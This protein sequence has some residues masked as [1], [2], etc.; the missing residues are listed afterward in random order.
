MNDL[1]IIKNYILYLKRK[2]NLQ[3][4]IHSHSS[5][6]LLK[7][8]FLTFNVHENPYCVYVKT[9]ENAQLHCIKK[10][11]QIIKK[12]KNGSFC[13]VCWAGVKE[14]IYPITHDD[15]V[16]GFISVSGFSNSNGNEY[17]SA[18]AQKY[19]LNY[20]Q[21]KSTYKT[22]KKDLPDKDYVDTLVYPLC[23][24]LELAH[25]KAAQETQTGD[26]LIG[27]IIQYLKKHYMQN[28]TSELL[29]KEFHCSRSTLSKIFNKE[30]K[31]PLREYINEI[32]IEAAKGLLMYT[33]L[34]ITEIAFS[35]GFNESY[36]FT[37]IFKKRVNMTPTQYRRKNMQ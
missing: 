28:I 37:T 1:L 33:R 35:V 4:T 3:I 7:K 23:H 36:Y 32:R 26:T 20:R 10:Q 22:L 2:C 34:D 17:I 24:M 9:C 12:A 11:P 25:I 8:D 16:V 21:L 5:R 27:R 30:L 18:V 6:L 15:N 14:Y 13:G 31:M 29:C 19:D